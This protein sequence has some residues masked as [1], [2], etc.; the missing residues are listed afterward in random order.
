MTS[1]DGEP[2]TAD[3]GGTAARTLDPEA[4]RALLDMLEGDREALV[5]I[6]DAFLDEAPVRLAEISDGD[7]Q[8]AGRAA[9]TLKAN[10]L[11][12][13]AAEF[14][15]RCQ[16]LEVAARADAPIVES[17]LIEA[18]DAEWERV[19]PALEALRDGAAG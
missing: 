19:R 7:L 16:R 17:G 6:V 1:T 14:A 4:I 15:S 18:L 11:T 2:N 3:S 5:E 12:F 8:T 10:G 9:H 13:G